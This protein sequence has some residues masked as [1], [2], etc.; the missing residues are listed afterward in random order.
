M[1]VVEIFL[2]FGATIFQENWHV[3]QTCLLG[4]TANILAKCVGRRRAEIQTLELGKFVWLTQFLG[5][6]CQM[7]HIS[8]KMSIDLLLTSW[9]CQ[10]MI[11]PSTHKPFVP[12]YSTLFKPNGFLLL[13]R[14]LFYFFISKVISFNLKLIAPL[15]IRLSVDPPRT[16]ESIW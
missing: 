10:I 8:K 16:F 15:Q 6:I 5:P 12:R 13:F 14:F 11:V 4:I 1:L 9:A 2:L 7:T 3:S